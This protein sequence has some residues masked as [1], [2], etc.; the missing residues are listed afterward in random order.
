MEDECLDE[1]TD[2]PYK[3]LCKMKARHVGKQEVP[4]ALPERLAR[5]ALL[6]LHASGPLSIA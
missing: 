3:S 6:Q 2:F 5:P 4:M 1:F